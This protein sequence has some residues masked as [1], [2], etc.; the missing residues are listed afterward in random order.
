MT[1][2]AG[3][4]YSLGKIDPDYQEKSLDDVL[5]LLVLDIFI[6]SSVNFLLFLTHSKYEFG[7]WVKVLHPKVKT[8]ILTTSYQ[9]ALGYTHYET[10]VKTAMK[11][12]L[13]CFIKFY[14]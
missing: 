7:V 14:G 11:L 10:Q 5:F 2:W 1:N 12:R 6:I 13:I 9:D 8:V 4:T 3:L